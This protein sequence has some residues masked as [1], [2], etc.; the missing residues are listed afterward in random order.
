VGVLVDNYCL[1][2]DSWHVRKA[3]ASIR[4]PGSEFSGG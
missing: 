4:Q 1:G 2:E 3:L